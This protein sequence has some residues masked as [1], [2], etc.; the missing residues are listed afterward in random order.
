MAKREEMRARKEKLLLMK[1]QLEKRKE[2]EEERRKQEEEMRGQYEEMKQQGAEQE[3]NDASNDNAN[4]N[5]DNDSNNKQSNMDRNNK[6]SDNAMVLFSDDEGGS[7]E[8]EDE[9]EEEP[10]GA[11][12][13]HMERWMRLF[14]QRPS[15][16]LR[17]DR[18]SRILVLDKFYD[19]MVGHLTSEVEDNYTKYYRFA[20]NRNVARSDALQRELQRKFPSHTFNWPEDK[21][22]MNSSKN[23]RRLSKGLEKGPGSEGGVGDDNVEGTASESGVEDGNKP[24]NGRFLD[25]AVNPARINIAARMIGTTAFFTESL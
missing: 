7:D 23:S 16:K 14:F 10:R 3:N 17:Q 15:S 24:G 20:G 13:K 11:K 4:T 18:P 8:G 1:L 12:E 9:D 2:K 21:R 19:R 25:S 5:N 6:E 22:K